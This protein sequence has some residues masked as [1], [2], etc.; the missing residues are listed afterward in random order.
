MRRHGNFLPSKVNV[1]S[2]AHQVVPAPQP[3]RGRPAFF[4]SAR[5]SGWSCAGWHQGC[6]LPPAALR[7]DS[8]ALHCAPLQHQDSVLGHLYIEDIRE[9]IRDGVSLLSKQ[10]HCFSISSS[11]PYIGKPMLLLRTAVCVVLQN[12]S[13]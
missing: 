8:P 7:Y 4:F 6:S 10:F 12:G 5:A 1:A 11:P 3:R 2:I 13:S 9:I